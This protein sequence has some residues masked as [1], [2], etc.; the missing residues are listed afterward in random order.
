MTPTRATVLALTL[1]T[2]AG[3]DGEDSS[4]APEGGTKQDRAVPVRVEKVTQG[5]LRVRLELV[6]EVRARREVEVAAPM[7]GRLT[8]VLVE[9][10]QEVE[11]G[12][13]LA[14]LDEA[15]LRAK[16]AEARAA[17]SVNQAAIRRAQADLRAVS[18]ELARKAPLAEDRLVTPQAMEKLRSR[19]EAAE[20]S[21][22][23][24]RSQAKQATASVGVLQ[25]QLRD[26]RLVAPFAGRVQAR[27]LDPGAVVAAGAPILRLVH[28]DPAVI[29]FQ[30]S[31]TQVGRLRARYLATDDEP[32]PVEITVQA[33]PERTWRGRLVRFSPALDPNNR[34]ATAEAEVDN[35]DGALMA[36]MYCRV[37]IDLGGRDDALLVPLKAL[38]EGPSE[39]NPNDQARSVFVVRQGRAKLL[40]I[41]VGVKQRRQAEVLDGLEASDQVVIEGQSGLREGRKVRVVGPEASGGER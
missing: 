25:Q 39:A 2:I 40:P 29:R 41:T 13:L 19:H 35:A 27:L 23:V 36:G 11:E 4:S 32:T 26:T 38:V 33:Y 20:A 8:E 6:G 7:S 5:E 18:D 15:P 24:T 17:Q 30:V 12:Q 1:L 14:R 34:A 10:G 9:M 3:C 28:A 22:E 37:T 21:L 16:M 31:E